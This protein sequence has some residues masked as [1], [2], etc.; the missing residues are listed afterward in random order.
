MNVS[1]Y[2]QSIVLIALALLCASNARAQNVTALFIDSQPGDP[3]GGGAQQTLQP[4]ADGAFTIARNFRNGVNASI[5]SPGGWSLEFAAFGN[6]AL[7]AGAYEAARRMA[8]AQSGNGIDVSGHFIGC[9]TITGRFL[10]REAVYDGGCN[11]IS[12]A[13][14]FEHHC[15]NGTAALFGAYRFNSTIADMTP[16]AGDYPHLRLAIATPVHGTVTANVVVC[17]ESGSGCIN[18]YGAVTIVTA[19]ATPDPGYL[20]AGWG[21]DCAGVSP[22]S[23]IVNGWKACTAFFQPTSLSPPATRTMLWLDSQTGDAVGQGRQRIFTPSNSVWQPQSFGGA[24]NSVRFAVTGASGISDES[25]TLTFAAPSGTALQAGKTYEHATAFPSVLTPQLNV[26]GPGFCST[27]AG[28]FTVLELVFASDGSVSRFAADFDQ[29]CANAGPG[30]YGAIR[31][32]ATDSS[33]VPFG[34]TYPLYTLTVQPDPNGTVSA[35]GIN[36]GSSGFTCATTL[37]Q[38]DTLSLTATPSPGFFFAGWSGDCSGLA[39]TSI[40]INRPETCSAVFQPFL[41]N[42]DRTLIQWI[43]QTVDV[44]QGPQTDAIGQGREAV[45][46]R[47]G[48]ALSLQGSSFQIQAQIVALSGNDTTTWTLTFRPPPQQ[49]LAVGMY[50]HSSSNAVVSPSM[51]VTGNGASCTEAGRFWIRELVRASD[52]TVLRFAADFEQHC[53]LAVP[54]LIGL[55]RYNSTV[56]SVEPFDGDYGIYRVRIARSAHGSVRGSGLDCGTNSAACEILPGG[57]STPSFTASPDPGYAFAG[58]TGDCHGGTSIVVF[59]NGPKECAAVFEPSSIGPTTFIR[60]V[61]DAANLLAPGR[62]ELYTPDNS[63]WSVSGS[64]SGL[65]VSVAGPVD[66]GDERWFVSVAAPIGQSLQAGAQY[67]VTNT[68]PS[69]SSPSMSVFGN[70]SCSGVGTFT[71]RQLTFSQN[72]S[73]DRA[74]IDLEYHCG[75]ATTPALRISIEYNST[76][77]VGT[78]ALDRSSLHF[79]GLMA[80]LGGIQSVGTPQI[81]HLTQSGGAGPVAWSATV[82]QPWLI[83]TPAQGT[84]GGTL[85]VSINAAAIPPISGVIL[86]NITITTPDDPKAAGPLQVFLALFPSSFSQPPFGSF[87]TPVSATTVAGSIPVTGWALDDVEV[88]RVRIMRDPV[89]VEGSALV[90][91]GNAIFIDGARPDVLA[92]YPAYPRSSRGGWGYLLLTNMLPNRGDGTFRL[93]AFAD[94]ADGHT[95]LLGTKTIFGDNKNSIAPFGAIDTPGQGEVVSGVV[96]NFGWVLAPAGRR[97]DPP[98]GG[99]VTVLVDGVA[100]GSPAGWAARPDLTALFPE[101]AGVNFALGVYSLDTTKLAN[102][103][104]TIAWIAEDNLG[105]VQGIGSRFFTVSNGSSFVAPPSVVG[106]AAS[107]AAVYAG[108]E[109]HDDATGGSQPGAGTILLGRRG[110]SLDAPLEYFFPDRDG[111]VT[112]NARELD[113]IELE[114]EPG[115]T[116]V[117]L[118]PRGERPLPAGAQID[119]STGLFTWTPGPGFV[120]RYDLILGGNRVRI[121]LRPKAD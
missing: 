59:V 93:Y 36:C 77:D 66:A 13:V 30:L 32:S 75:T 27:V 53:G 9:N 83:V 60:L 118:T 111:V 81:V 41:S 6:V 48:S 70:Q 7:T 104:H 58:W 55:V 16:F 72:N 71:V 42:G 96:P 89:P 37:P 24:T 64:P 29:H 119:R 113:R 62:S 63:E 56:S 88:T 112:I 40:F 107:A 82:D 121:V 5:G 33:V 54:A 105:A 19:T 106:P 45:F 117:S 94:D 84:G 39:S 79:A 97:A 74:A 102:G 69:T 26:D 38:P 101:F 76:V 116:G 20:F 98:G 95:T 57:A 78:L 3:I 85:T 67:V 73:I 114:L 61:G 51:S 34:G 49:A 23:I 109:A 87:D 43:S 108:S 1:R 65:N 103:V 92:A 90:F 68:F 44:G 100:V 11:V 35:V 47:P 80:P 86:G 25:W 21:G 52:G 46:S 91:I 99:T 28:R 10:V 22:A 115:A 4:A 12:F 18:D 8:F 17:D 2:L 15:D 14:D 110:F 31:Y 120:G 50:L